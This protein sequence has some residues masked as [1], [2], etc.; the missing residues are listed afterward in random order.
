MCAAVHPDKHRPRGQNLATLYDRGSTGPVK[1]GLLTKW[2]RN[3]RK[4]GATAS[5]KMLA[6]MKVL[7]GTVN[8]AVR[9]G[10]F[11]GMP[12]AVTR[13]GCPDDVHVG[14]QGHLALACSGTRAHHDGA[15]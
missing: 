7:Q 9:S 5:Y 2:H 12:D 6:D 15:R 1:G 10:K 14:F 3:V 4:G 13:R 11:F 8:R